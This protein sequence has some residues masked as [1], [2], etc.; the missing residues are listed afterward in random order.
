MTEEQVKQK[1]YRE[2]RRKQGI[3]NFCTE[4]Y[5]CVANYNLAKA[6]DFDPDKWC[7]H[8]KLEHYWS[9]STL[10]ENNMYYGVGPF[11]LIWLPRDVHDRDRSLLPDDS[12]FHKRIL[13]SKRGWHDSDK[14]KATQFHQ[15]ES[16]EEKRAYHREYQRKYRE[17]HPEYYN[18]LQKSKRR[19]LKALK[20]AGYEEE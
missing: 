19:R 12:V 9:K 3:T 10:L 16:L 15:L 14:Y 4:N 2:E 13:E 8:H 5:D 11:D 18:T 20:N 7:I 17:A 6:D 1:Q